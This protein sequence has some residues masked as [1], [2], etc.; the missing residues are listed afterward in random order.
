MTF[1]GQISAGDK[2]VNSGT[3]PGKPGTSGNLSLERPM[4]ID[5]VFSALTVDEKQYNGWICF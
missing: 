4:I 2:C 3:V 1:R 5:S